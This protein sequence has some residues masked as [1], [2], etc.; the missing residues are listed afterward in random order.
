MYREQ[1]AI[2]HQLNIKPVI[3]F[4]SSK[5]TESKDN[6]VVFHH[7]INNLKDGDLN[8]IKNQT[9][10]SVL[11]QA[12][13]FFDKNEINLSLLIAKIKIAFNEKKCLCTN[14]DK[15]LELNQKRLNNLED[16]DN[17]IRVIFTVDKL[18]E[19]WDVLNLFDIVRLYEGQNTGGSNKGKIG[20]KTISEAQL[21]GRGARYCQFFIVIGAQAFFFIKSIFYFCN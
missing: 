18:N 12:F 16:K 19:G 4:K 15:E 11:I 6:Q 14:N 2:N 8:V 5:I 13:D 21:I 1:I 10:I 20:K 7:L 17:S 9:N 3:L